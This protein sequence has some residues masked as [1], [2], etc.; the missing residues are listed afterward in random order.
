MAGEH[1][2]ERRAPKLK[3]EEVSLETVVLE[4]DRAKRKITLADQSGN[5]VTMDASEVQRFN[6]IEVGDR[7]LATYVTLLGAEF[8]EPTAAE[9]ETPLVVLGA[10]ERASLIE[11]P[12][13]FAGA[14]IKAVVTV[15][16]ID[17]AN[18]LVT[19]KGPRG[20]YV[21]LPVQDPVLL[22]DLEL[23]EVVI[24]TYG[25]AVGI[26]LQKQ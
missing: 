26:A 11:D 23:G 9:K 6:E 16:N 22:Q 1:G 10:A 4:I 20:N 19:I 2:A 14:L 3:V 18:R 12:G 24:M 21:T 25:E 7:V 13:A 5:K 15:E 8:R 17:K